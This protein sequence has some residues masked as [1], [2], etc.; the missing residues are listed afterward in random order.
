MGKSTFALVIS[1]NQ[2]IGVLDDSE[3]GYLTTAYSVLCFPM[4]ATIAVIWT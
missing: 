1:D 3:V 4:V 2:Y